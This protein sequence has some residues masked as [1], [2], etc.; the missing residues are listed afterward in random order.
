MRDSLF[1]WAMGLLKLLLRVRARTHA[2]THAHTQGAGSSNG[3]EC[4]S[5][6]HRAAVSC[7]QCCQQTGSIQCAHNLWRCC[8]HHAQQGQ[9]L[10]PCRPPESIGSVVLCL[11]DFM[12]TW[13]LCFR[14]RAHTR[15]QT[16][17]TTE[18]ALLSQHH[19]CSDTV[20]CLATCGDMW[21]Q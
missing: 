12:V 5:A 19:S 8:V 2:R 1:L 3:R 10:E 15:A 7:E 9:G 17:E 20:W 11:R 13:A 18:W 14:L 6:L 16:S 21:R 4:G